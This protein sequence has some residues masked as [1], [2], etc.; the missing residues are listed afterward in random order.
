[1]TV[2]VEKAR[3]RYSKQKVEKSGH[4]LKSVHNRRALIEG[5]KRNSFFSGIIFFNVSLSRMV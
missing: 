1:L 5:D 2:A 4:E 3:P